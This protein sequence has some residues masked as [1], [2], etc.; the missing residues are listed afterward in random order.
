MYTLYKVTNL[1]TD[2]Y[3]IGVHKETGTEYFGS[4]LRVKRSVLKYG[5]ENFTKEILETFDTENTAFE[6]EKEVLTEHIGNALCLNISEGG[7][8]GSNFSGKKH[9]E[10]TKQK[11][12]QGQIGRKFKKTQETIDKE[13]QL[14]YERNGGKWFSDAT[15]E[16]IR[17]RA[18]NRN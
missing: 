13:R 2:E 15:V 3:Y 11:I 6:R 7:K 16:K 17:Q 10:E 1:I 14:R 18:L 12:A 5:K 8:G 9:S 4:G